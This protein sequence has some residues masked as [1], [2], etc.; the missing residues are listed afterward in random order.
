EAKLV[1]SASPDA[2]YRRE[3]SWREFDRQAN[4]FAISNLKAAFGREKQYWDALKKIRDQLK[5]TEGYKV[6][7]VCPAI[8]G[9]INYISDVLGE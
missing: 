6:G 8:E 2:P 4:R 1:E 5:L 3:L 9:L 7:H